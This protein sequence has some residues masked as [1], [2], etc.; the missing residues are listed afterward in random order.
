MHRQQTLSTSPHS[1]HS[2]PTMSELMTPTEQHTISD[3][4]G[5]LNQQARG[6]REVMASL[7]GNQRAVEALMWSQQQRNN[8]SGGR[9]GGSGR[10][11]DGSGGGGT[12]SGSGVNDRY[13]AGKRDWTGDGTGA[14][15]RVE[16]H[17]VVRLTIESL[18][19]EA[20][21]ICQDVE[22]HRLRL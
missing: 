11:S 18:R 10:G 16:D 17:T 15:A 12:G 1:A 7:L 9:G 20:R 5:F 19:F 8:G 21:A 2:H 6:R 3:Y 13:G 14:G 4:L 22:R